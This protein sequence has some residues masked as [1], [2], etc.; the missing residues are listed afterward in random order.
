M[1][2][3]VLRKGRG[4]QRVTQGAAA[5]L[6]IAGLGA[7]G[8][9]LNRPLEPNEPRITSTII[10]Q[11][12]QSAVDKID[13]V[14][15][16]DNS[17]SMAD[18]QKILEAAVPD[19]VR[20]LVNPGC[21]DKTGATVAQPASP[22]DDC[23][24]GSQRE[25]K[26][27]LDIH[28][29]IVSSSIGGHGSDSCSVK[30]A[31]TADCGAADNPGQ[32]DRG[33][34]IARTEQCGLPGAQTSAPTY[35]NKGF[36]AWDPS[37]KLMPAG[38]KNLDNF[39]ANLG[40]MVVGTGQIGC[41]FESQM[42]SWYRFLVD[43]EPYDK[44]T[45]D[46]S[47][48]VIE[49]TGTD[50]VLLQQRADFLRPNSLLAVIMLTDENDCSVRESGIGF[51]AL[52]QHLLKNPNTTYFLP[53][54][55]QECAANPGDACCR[56]CS[57]DQKGCPA[58]D[59]CATKPSLN[60]LEDALNLRCFD[61]KRRFGFDFLYPIDRYTTGLLS[62]TVPNRKGELVPNPIYQDLNPAD[63]VTGGRPT[64]QVFLAGIVGV[65]W[66]LIAR[67]QADLKKGFQSFEELSANG[68]WDKI[69]GDPT[70]Y[71]PAADSHMIESID[72][73]PNLPTATSG[74][75]DPFSGHE[76][77]IPSRADLQYAC[78][79]DL[80]APQ[81]CEA[82]NLSCDCNDPAVKDNPL[83]MGT[84]QMKA[85]AYPGLRELATLKSVGSQGI[86]A[87]VCPAQLGDI[88]AADYG[89]RP[90]I[91]AIIDRLKVALNGKC[92]PRQLTPDANNQVQCLVIEASK[93]ADPKACCDP[94]AARHPIA[95]GNIGAQRAAQ[96]NEFVKA[97]GYNCFCEITQLGDPEKSSKAEQSACQD[98]PSGTPQFQDKD[99]TMKNAN[100]WC[101]VDS[102][103]NPP[104]GSPDIVKDCP[105]TEK[106]IIRFV[107]AGNPTS[108]APLFITCTG[109]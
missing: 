14:L 34:L 9:C 70:T 35:S 97:G 99:G 100:G 11:L 38:E 72:P 57:A 85:K 4:W 69:L 3:E 78:I 67:D 22:T 42:E 107:G 1:T 68:T 53:R 25:F 40:K 76:Y 18:K 81:E 102:T 37:G 61:Q 39:I 58:D 82:G 88:N 43:P 49:V 6:A 13:L 54:A 60:Q 91:G 20:G 101:Y 36:L 73:R 46:P 95:E 5:L 27:V 55:R 103:T 23:P 65:P 31:A 96:A 24:T 16:V 79:F 33:H 19:L 80:P 50:A 89:Y 8:G 30:A 90:A 26:P 86:V 45:V 7:V 15:M 109:D 94:K 104:T 75:E 84:T 108:G 21:V 32:D 62:P 64:D 98:D 59:L 51:Y 47:K 28:V 92:L 93:A 63:N 12:S 105:S 71:K 48:G 56:S 66:Q 106:R 41:G 17:R 52:Q 74:Q 10:E 29:G 77:T 83:C 87:S 2:D 44:I